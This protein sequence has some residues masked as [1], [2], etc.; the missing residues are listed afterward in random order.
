MG[1]MFGMRAA[2]RAAPVP[3]INR[4]LQYLQPAFYVGGPSSR[5]GDPIYVAAAG[6]A[7][8]MAAVSASTGDTRATTA[9][10][11]RGSTACE[12]AMTGRSESSGSRAPHRIG[13]AS[14]M[15]SAASDSMVCK[16]IREGRDFAVFKR[17]PGF[18][19]GDFTG[20]VA[21]SQSLDA[22]LK[23]L[24]DEQSVNVVLLGEVHDDKV[25]HR[26]QLQ[27]LA[28]CID[29]CRACGRRVVL[30]MEM[31]ETDV[32]HVLDEYVLQKAIREEDFLQDARPWANY[33]EDYRPL[34]ELCRESGVR[35]VAANAPRRYV[36]L[37]SRGGSKALHR[38]TKTDDGRL[39]GMLPPLPLPPASSSYRRKFTEMIAEQMAPQANSEAGGCPYIGFK[40]EDA[41]QVKPEMLEAQCLWDHSMAKSICNAFK[42]DASGSSRDQKQPLVVHVCGA[43]HCAH[44][45]GI[46]EALPRY[47]V[48]SPSVPQ[49]APPPELGNTCWLPMDAALDQPEDTSRR[50]REGAILDAEYEGPKP[51]PSGVLSIVCWPAA[52]NLTVRASQNGQP[53][54]SLAVMGDWV[55]ITEE[56]WE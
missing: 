53:L 13:V 1:V 6:L 41:R 27:M 15:D 43:F 3:L 31:F 36:S 45:L 4:S 8:G 5:G 26:L 56:T 47:G 38:L 22:L 19:A 12:E 37:V 16:D 40:S 32:Q 35:V 42:D 44:G 20:A 34:V 29:A 33:T 17:P 30:S 48:P 9:F 7:I 11:F 18:Q 28:H 54:P 25:A 50:G 52:V 39:R 14:S 10:G 46:P 2:Q 24:V 55:V 23:A 49:A 21:E 51:C